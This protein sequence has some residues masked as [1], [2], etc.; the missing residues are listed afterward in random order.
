MK[1]YI[2]VLPILLTLLLAACAKDLSPNTYSDANIDSG[3]RVYHGVIISMRPVKVKGNSGFG[4]PAGLASGAV[5]G[6]AVGGGRGSIVTGVAGAIAGGIAGHAIDKSVNTQNAI[7]YIVQLDTRKTMSVVQAPTNLHVNQ[8][9]LL[10][11]GARVRLIPDT[12]PVP[13]QHHAKAA[14]PTA[15]VTKK[16]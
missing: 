12:T 15:N 6:S 5:L 16:A 3:S 7:E 1:R 4:G 9:V 2:V 10:L 11:Y 8:R 14:K 13:A